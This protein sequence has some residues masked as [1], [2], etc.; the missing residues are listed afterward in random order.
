VITGG[1]ENKLDVISHSPAFRL[2]FPE[3]VTKMLFF[4]TKVVEFV[5]WLT[6]L[7]MR[8]WPKNNPGS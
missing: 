7:C 2:K 8:I 5:I 6:E 4:D 3:N 1:P